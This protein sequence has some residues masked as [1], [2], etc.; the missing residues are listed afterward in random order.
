M[1]SLAL[2]CPLCFGRPSNAASEGC[3]LAGTIRLRTELIM[4]D[5][6]TSESM[7]DDILRMI[8]CPSLRDGNLK[9]AAAGQLFGKHIY[10]SR[11]HNETRPSHPEMPNRLDL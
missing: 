3:P 8:V 4:S 2:A 5:L 7:G 10:R 1:W 9:E 6:Q 11:P